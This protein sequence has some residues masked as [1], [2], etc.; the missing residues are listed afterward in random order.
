MGD[1]SEEGEGGSN[2]NECEGDIFEFYADDIDPNGIDPTQSL[3]FLK[4]PQQLL[5]LKER[6]QGGA[7]LEEAGAEGEKEEKE[8]EEEEEEEDE[9]DELRS[10]SA[11]S[12]L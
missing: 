4:H 9:I 2:A 1:S 7:Q 8:E 10:E 5:A 6:E 11:K 12:Q 3:N